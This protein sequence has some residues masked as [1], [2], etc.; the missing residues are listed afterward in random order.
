MKKLF[1]L[2]VKYIPTIQLVGMLI[3]NTLC[4]Y[5]INNVITELCDILIGNSIA[6]IVMLY[7]C[8]YTFGFCKWHR[9]II[10]ATLIN[11]LIVAYDRIFVIPISDINLLCSYYII[12]GI[13]ILLA[14]RSHVKE[15]KRNDERK[16]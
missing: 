8:S 14:A 7:I 10:T 6:N 11:V 4:K 2:S 5:N 3:N 9:Y 12:S 16:D 15:I 13:F 1:V